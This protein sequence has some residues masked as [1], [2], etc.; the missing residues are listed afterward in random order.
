MRSRQ[1]LGLWEVGWPL[2]STRKRCFELEIVH[3]YPNSVEMW[4]PE[5]QTKDLTPLTQRLVSF[6]QDWHRLPG[7][8]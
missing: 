4:L 6:P 1:C 7:L 5:D 8:Q 3:P 2:L